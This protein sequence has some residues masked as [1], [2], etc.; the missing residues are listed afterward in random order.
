[1]LISIYVN[2]IYEIAIYVMANKPVI[3]VAMLISKV[4]R[5]RP[6]SMG[7]LCPMRFANYSEC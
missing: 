4:M 1:M 5:F 6:K 3:S 7:F 2:P